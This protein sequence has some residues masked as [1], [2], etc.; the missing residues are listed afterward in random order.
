MNRE[1][2]TQSKR[3]RFGF[4]LLEVLIAL[5]IIGVLAAIAIPVL[6]KLQLRSTSAE[7]ASNL[8]AIHKSEE[9]WFSEFGYY[10]SATP[11]PASWGGAHNQPF[12]DTG[13][14][15]NLGWSPEGQVYFQYA[16]A[17]AGAGYT[18]DAAADLDEDAVP[19][20]WGYVH[21]DPF[22]VVLPGALSCTGVWL[23]TASASSAN[24]IGP[25]G[26][27]DGRSEF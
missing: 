10:V 18:A 12:V 1:R 27:A 23:P 21:P 7:A 17:A 15:S 2:S 5:A 26:A 11:S 24:V 13:G 19:Q 16:V 22:G 6:R 9:T 25:C 4:T 8:A 20:V 14:F 3:P